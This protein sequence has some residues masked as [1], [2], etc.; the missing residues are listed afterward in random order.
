MTREMSSPRRRRHSRSI[1][2]YVFEAEQGKAAALNAAM[3][4]SRGAVLVFTDD[5]ARFEADW[6]D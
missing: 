2:R 5:D 6:L 1:L 3:R 4:L